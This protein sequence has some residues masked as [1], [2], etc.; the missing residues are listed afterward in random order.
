MSARVVDLVAAGDRE[1]WALAGDQ[2]YVDLD[3]SEANLPAGTRLALG[4]A[5]I[6]VTPEPHTGCVKFIVALRE[7]R[8]P[9]RQHEAVSPPAPAR[10]EREGDRAGHGLERRHDPQALTR[11]VAL[12]R[13]IN[14]AKRRRV[15]MGE[16]RE[17]LEGHGYEDVRTHLQS[18]N[19]VLVEPA[20]AAEAGGAAGAAARAGLG[21]EVRVL[22]RTRAELAAVVRRDPLGKVAT[23][24]SRYL[25]SF[26]SKRLPAKV[27]RELEA[28]EIA[29]AQLVIDGRELYAWYPDGVQRAPLAK[30][31]DDKRLGVVSTA[32]NWNTVTKLLQLLDD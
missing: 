26:L 8:A 32:R 21:I 16:L 22:V 27:A 4:S 2:L 13:G 15:A 23:N 30:L 25:V 20:R 1:R 14:L 19:V 5:V 28:A 17:L 31:L 6:E 7:R 9:L 24:G 11:Q 10:A 3:I 18:G 12:L 29:P